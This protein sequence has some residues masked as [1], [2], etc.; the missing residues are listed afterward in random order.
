MLYARNIMT[1]DVI[2][3]STETPINEVARLMATN[4]ISGVPVVDP[5]SGELVGMIT[6]LEM[7][8]RQAKFD[9]P[10]YSMFLDALVVLPAE[11]SEEQLA[12][13]LATRADELMERTVY[14]IRED[15]TIEEVA[16]LMFE[17]KV[18]PVPVISL[19]DEL[20]GI[21]S[22][23]D[24][25]RL[26]ARDFTDTDQQDAEPLAADSAADPPIGE[27]DLPAPPDR[28]RRG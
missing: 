19:N 1:P 4:G 27:F 18:N 15:A 17:R 23:S 2:T 22:R 16:S 28:A 8:E 10:I 5:A 3:V 14:S 24:I 21:V 13:I 6:E 12:R 26:M 11:H 9:A 7:I 25:I 20:I